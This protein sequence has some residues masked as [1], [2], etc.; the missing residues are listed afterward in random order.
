MWNTNVF[1]FVNWFAYTDLQY[2]LPWK[3]DSQKQ[4]KVILL[5]IEVQQLCPFRGFLSK[6]KA[7][8]AFF[9]ILHRKVA[10]IHCSIL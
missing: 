1:I 5:S 3:R 9:R 2:V 7:L 6:M 4:Y 10:E 8:F